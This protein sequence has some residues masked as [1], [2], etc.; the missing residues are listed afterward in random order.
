[1]SSITYILILLSLIL[2]TWLIYTKIV[3]D[4]TVKK[5]VQK[6]DD[7]NEQ[8]KKENPFADD[9]IEI[10]KRP[11]QK[12]NARIDQFIFERQN[13]VDH[14]SK[15]ERYRKEYIGNVAHEL[16]TPIFNIQGYIETLAD[17]G[18]YDPNINL[19]YIKKA[20]RSVSRMIAMIDDLD[21]ITQLEGGNLILDIEEF[22][23]VKLTKDV[24]EIVELSAA[25]KQIKL[26]F[27]RDYIAP[28]FVYGD[29]YKIRQVL[30]NLLNNSI[31]YGR[32][33]GSTEISFIKIKDLVEV[34]IKDTGIGISE[35]HL[36]RL[37]ERFYRVDKGRSREQGG[38]GLGL[39]IVKH[40]IEA[41]ESQI[42]VDSK[43]G[44]GTT[45]KFKLKSNL[46]K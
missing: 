9:Y 37:F 1:M 6:L 10:E 25:K 3:F 26:R 41:H 29:R 31:K 39:A 38:T 24:F 30:V 28:V 21:A 32:D 16:K 46:M 22:D 45:F 44:V 34:F 12:L 13:E 8:I 36:P 15:L 19:K 14:I 18:I 42:V 5:L 20:E 2:L 43:V 23:L 7:F 27:N 33:N 40:I 35:E 17:G 11:I 4:K